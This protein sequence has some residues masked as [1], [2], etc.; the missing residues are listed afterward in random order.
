MNLLGPSLLMSSLVISHVYQG[1]ISFLKRPLLNIKEY[2]ALL[3]NLRENIGDKSWKRF[4]MESLRANFNQV[5]ISAI[6]ISF[7]AVW[8]QRA[9]CQKIVLKNFAKFTEKYL[10]RSLILN[11]L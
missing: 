7:V 1:F 2:L 11:K 9:F 6:L 8:G 4:F 3:H 5:C 10:R